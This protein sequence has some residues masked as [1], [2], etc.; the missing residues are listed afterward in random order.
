VLKKLVCSPEFIEFRLVGGA[1]LSLYKGTGSLLTSICLLMRPMIALILQF[2]ILDGKHNQIY[3]LFKYHR[4]KSKKKPDQ[5]LS[6]KLFSFI[7][8]RLLKV[9]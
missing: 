5:K 4:K 6:F 7:I 1:A 2:D 8:K 3:I 9:A